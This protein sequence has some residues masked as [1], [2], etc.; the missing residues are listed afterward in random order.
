MLKTLVQL[1]SNGATKNDLKSEYI[2]KSE[3]TVINPDH[4]GF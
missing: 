3:R 4:S 1:Y 2:F